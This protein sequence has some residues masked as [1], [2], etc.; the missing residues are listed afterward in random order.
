MSDESNNLKN[1]TERLAILIPEMESILENAAQLSC[2][3]LNQVRINDMRVLTDEQNAMTKEI[4]AIRD[5]LD[6][7]SHVFSDLNKRVDALEKK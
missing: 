6:K 5:R 2:A 7:A 3:Y 1:L 4:Q